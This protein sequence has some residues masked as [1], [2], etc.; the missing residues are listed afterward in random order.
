M[1]LPLKDILSALTNEITTASVR[2]DIT[3]A[4]WQDVYDDNDMLNEFTPSRVRIRDLKITI[5]LAINE[6]PSA[7]VIMP[8]LTKKQLIH[9][10]PLKISV[11][12]RSKYALNI[13]DILLD[14]KLH[15]LS[16]N[17]EQTILKI[18]SQILPHLKKEDFNFS[19]L[20][21]LQRQFSAQSNDE[22]EATFIY[23]AKE[24]EQ[25]SSE[26]LIKIELSIEID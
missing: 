16:N 12:E 3:R 10:L 19:Y 26:H 9:L 20:E 2:S 1:A 13:R 6:I 14:K 15:L 25:I 11:E 5:P 4:H 23:S 7:K 24:L 22:R 21:K 8:S 18:C 17:I